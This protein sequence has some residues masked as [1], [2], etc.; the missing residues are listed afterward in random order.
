MGNIKMDISKSLGDSLPF[1][2]ICQIKVL[3][4]ID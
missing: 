1:R 3:G 2:M 4:D